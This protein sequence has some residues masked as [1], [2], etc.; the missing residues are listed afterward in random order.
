MPCIVGKNRITCFRV[1]QSAKIKVKAGGLDWFCDL[2]KEAYDHVPK[3]GTISL[4]DDGA[5]I[6]GDYQGS[7]YKKFKKW[8]TE[9]IGTIQDFL[10]IT[11]KGFDRKGVLDTEMDKAKGK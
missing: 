10:D 6:P 7:R 8:G 11:E 3:D 2:T 9:F 1:P 5:G 4:Y